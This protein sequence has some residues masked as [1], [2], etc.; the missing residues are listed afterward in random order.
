MTLTN[1]TKKQELNIYE[2]ATVTGKVIKVG[3]TEKKDK[4][5][6]TIVTDSE[7]FITIIAPLEIEVGKLLRVCVQ[8]NHK[9]NEKDG[10][11]YHTIFL[12]DNNSNHFIKILTEGPNLLA[13]IE[14][15]TK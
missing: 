11:V 7:R 1:T 10:N 6:L 5:K 4:K 3:E 14:N 8:G 12:N 2:M 9:S 13:N 15:I